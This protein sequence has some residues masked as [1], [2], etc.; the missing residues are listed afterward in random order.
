MRKNIDLDELT[1]TKLKIISA[2][3]NLSVKKLIEKAVETYVL[4]KEKESIEAMTDEE[5]QDFGLWLLLQKA[6]TSEQVS[7]NDIFNILD[8]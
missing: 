2:F 7:K 4:E 6:D 3:E 1:L 8:A 5:K